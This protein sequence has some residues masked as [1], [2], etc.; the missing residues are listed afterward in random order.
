MEVIFV[1]HEEFE[2]AKG[3]ETK[4]NNLLERMRKMKFMDPACGSGN[5]LIITP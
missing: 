4:L 5:F 3:N 1:T 2:K